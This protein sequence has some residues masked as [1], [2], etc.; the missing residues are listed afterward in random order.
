MKAP[1]RSRHMAG[2]FAAAALFAGAVGAR[3]QPVTAL[4][5]VGPDSAPRNPASGYL[6]VYTETEN[7]I[8]VGDIVY[9]P[10]TAYQIYD[11]HGALFKS[12]RN[13]MSERDE[14]PTRVSLPPGHYTVI[15]KS[16]TKGQV[17]VPVI[18]SGLRTT[19]VNLEKRS[20][21]G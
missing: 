17:A 18:V 9:Y 15:G 21:A 20:H 1:K 7:P 13:H 5:A 16:E 10:H 6:V 12:V 3:S 11:D 8:N 2:L 19:V 4:P 14:Q